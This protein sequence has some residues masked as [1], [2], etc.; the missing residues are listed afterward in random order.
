MES[1]V[2]QVL[3]ELSAQ[4]MSKML[5]WIPVCGKVLSVDYKMYLRHASVWMAA[6]NLH[7]FPVIL[8]FFVVE[9]GYPYG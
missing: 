6:C 8:A 4:W 1:Q 7:L 2:V 5:L 9:I 3:V